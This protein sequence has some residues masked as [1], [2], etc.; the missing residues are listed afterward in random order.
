MP[1]NREV[2]EGIR[3]QRPACAGGETG[4][5]CLYGCVQASCTDHL[6]CVP[7]CAHGWV[8]SCCREGG[9]VGKIVLDPVG[10]GASH[11]GL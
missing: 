1:M 6:L 10:A 9:R 5:Q 8:D 11:I 3:P 4:E 2:R 7:L